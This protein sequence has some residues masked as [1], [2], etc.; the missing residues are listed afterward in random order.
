MNEA[1]LKLSGYV[2]EF[3]L[4][5]VIQFLG[6]MKKNGSLRIFKGEK[7]EEGISLYFQDG[8]LIHAV[9]NE[10]KGIGAFYM[11]LDSETGYFKFITGDKAPEISINHP[12]P[13]LLLE[14]QRR[15]D[16]LRYIQRFL[17]PD[18][19]VL[20]IVSDIEEVPSLNTYEWRILSMVNGR[21]S[22]KRICEKIGDELE[23]KKIMVK[24]FMKNVVS[25][26]SGEA[27]WKELVP[28]LIPSGELSVDRPYPPLLRTNLLLKAIDGKLT[29]QDLIIK[30][31]M[32]ENDLI[33]DIKLLFD[34]HWIKFPA[35]QASLFNR[36][37]NE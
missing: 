23:V 3:P 17:P 36:M 28:V 4:V 33:E 27:Y 35:T 26:H 24:L 22:L 21:R 18:E 15:A 34:T 8:N 2:S 9:F 16:E 12:I 31:N 25:T 7:K 14:S 19:S 37:R 30:L 1:T 5:E 6:N 10:V 32:K 11:A 20:F 29:L 13:F